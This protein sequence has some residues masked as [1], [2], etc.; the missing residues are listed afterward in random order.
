MNIWV[1]TP[2]DIIT[3]Q[4]VRLVFKGNVTDVVIFVDNFYTSK[5]LKCPILI[6]QGFNRHH[7]R[8]RQNIEVYQM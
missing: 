7:Y 2:L 4:K 6:L 1:Y 5:D 8:M 3:P